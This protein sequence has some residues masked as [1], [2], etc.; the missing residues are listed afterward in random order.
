VRKC[1]SILTDFQNRLTLELA[2]RLLEF[3]PG[4]STTKQ[5]PLVG[6]ADPSSKRGYN[7]YERMPP[8]GL[9]PQVR[10][11]GRGRGQKAARKRGVRIHKVVF[12][13]PKPLKIRF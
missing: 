1:H 12:P 5:S 3:A 7:N 8:E 10:I 9:A 6:G 2:P 4:A 11:Q 13:P